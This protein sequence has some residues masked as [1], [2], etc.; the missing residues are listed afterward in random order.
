MI[1][2]HSSNE[3]NKIMTQKFSS[4]QL[5]AARALLNWSRAYLAKLSQVSEPTIHRLENDMG[6]PETKTQNKL[7]RILEHAGI[8]FLEPDGVRR[9]PEGMEIFYGED[10]FREFYDFIYA[11][12]NLHGGTIC[13]SG[14]DESLYL[15]Y[16][17][18]F[19]DQHIVRM[20][21]LTKERKDIKMRILIC[22]GDTNFIASRYASYRWQN[23]ESFSPTSFYVFSDYL[24]LISFR[25]KNAPKVILLH[26]EEFANAYRQQF[27]DEWKRAKDPP[28]K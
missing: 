8:E 6:E 11:Q 17:T 4:S 22:E 19:F 2:F 27:M 7:R 5:R 21:S 12:V 20:E 26:S 10:G 13:V 14:V 25:S 18:S 3:L 24:A 1:Y 15:N 16:Q 23:K 9:R 28:K